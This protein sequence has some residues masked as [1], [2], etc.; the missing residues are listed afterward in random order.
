MC[1]SSSQPIVSFAVDIHDP[2]HATGQ[3]AWI[4]PEDGGADQG[5][6]H[7]PESVQAKGWPRP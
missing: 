2:T 3:D 4:M 5:R 6:G 1:F 7:S